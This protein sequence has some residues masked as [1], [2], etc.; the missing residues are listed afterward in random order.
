MR[1]L[2]LAVGCG[3]EAPPVEAPVAEAA[4]PPPVLTEVHL[5]ILEVERPFHF[6]DEFRGLATMVVELGLSDLPGVVARVPGD[7]A[8]PAVLLALPAARRQVDA[9]FRAWGTED[10]LTLELELCVA[11][12]TCTTTTAAT[13][14]AAPWDAFGALL[15]GAAD[16][17]GLAVPPEVAAG[18]HTPGSKDPYAELIT[19]RGAATFYGILP[20]PTEPD[21]RR[22]NPVLRAVFLDPRQPVA[23]WSL[24][25]WQ[26][27]TTADGGAAADTLAR[28]SLVRPWSPMLDADRATVLAAQGKSDQAVLAWEHIRDA[29]PRD[30]RFLEPTA[31]ALL[32]AHRPED[33][34]IGRA[35]V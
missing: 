11:G 13:T 33:A 20:P 9:R 24:A 5:P 21:D 10:A 6:S 12:G 8:P 35:H 2:V 32:A 17:L 31:R 1:L 25:R 26:V 28:A 27:G 34:E 16:G 3:G 18:W 19:G 7:A 29:N 14:R 30:P 22:S 4:P 15:E 23:L